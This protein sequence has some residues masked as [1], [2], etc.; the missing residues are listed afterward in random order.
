MVKAIGILGLSPLVHC[1]LSTCRVASPLSYQQCAA[2]WIDF[3]FHSRPQFGTSPR[4][5]L[6]ESASSS[7]ITYKLGAAF[8]AKGRRLNP[9]EDLFSFNSR[10]QSSEPFT[11]RPASGQDA[12]FVSNVG[13]GNSIAFGVA[14]GVGGWSDS[15]IDSADFS[16]ALCRYMIKNAEG[17]DQKGELAAQN[18]LSQGYK[19]VVA[20][21]SIQGG[22]STACVAV[23]HPDGLLQVA[24]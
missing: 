21:T 7:S 15:G 24:K 18:L 13:H 22:G 10:K 11:G 6:H 12:F 19:D 1:S 14:D 4:R 17:N 5:S 2:Q 23:G 3:R 20:D 9:K 16:H 8:S